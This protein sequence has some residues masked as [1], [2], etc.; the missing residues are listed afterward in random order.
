MLAYIPYMDPMGLLQIYE[1]KYIRK[2]THDQHSD[3]CNTATL[4]CFISNFRSYSSLQHLTIGDLHVLNPTSLQIT[5]GP[6]DIDIQMTHKN[7]S[8]T[9]ILYIIYMVGYMDGNSGLMMFLHVS[10]QLRELLRAA[11]V[12]PIRMWL[13]PSAAL[14]SSTAIGGAG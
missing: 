10:S 1:H 8:H 5:V 13:K 11:Y 14:Q 7:Y 12:L 6:L 9:Y 4:G 3:P 2:I